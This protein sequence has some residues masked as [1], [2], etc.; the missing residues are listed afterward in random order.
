MREAGSCRRRCVKVMIVYSETVIAHT[1]G[2]P[3]HIQGLM[4]MNATGFV[5]IVVNGECH[6]RRMQGP[7]TRAGP[8]SACCPILHPI[9]VDSPP[10]LRGTAAALL[11]RWRCVAP[12]CCQDGGRWPTAIQTRHAHASPPRFAPNA[13]LV[14]RAA[15]CHDAAAWQLAKPSHPRTRQE[16][17][18][19][20]PMSSLTN[21]PHLL[22]RLK[23][24][25]PGGC[26]GRPARQLCGAMRC[27][28]IPEPSKAAARPP[29]PRLLRVQLFRGPSSPRPGLRPTCMRARCP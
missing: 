26:T 20:Y 12:A 13:V 25:R 22:T 11:H 8:Q 23:R 17:H 4:D 28:R 16:P 6:E 1:G 29:L 5:S 10:L 24:G 18:T 27:A 14:G 19:P 7:I 9:T 2:G 15:L 3:E 21:I